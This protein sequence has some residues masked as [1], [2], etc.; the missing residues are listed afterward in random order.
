[1]IALLLAIG[2]TLTRLMNADVYEEEVITRAER[3]IRNAETKGCSIPL[4]SAIHSDYRL[5]RLD[6]VS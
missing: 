2:R 3:L 1:M 5:Q 4:R 6:Q